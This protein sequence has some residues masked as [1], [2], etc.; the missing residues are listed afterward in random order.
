VLMLVSGFAIGQPLGGAERFGVG[1]ACHLDQEQFE[2]IVCGFW[3]RGVPAE[4]HWRSL[5]QASRIETFEA[6]DRSRGFTLARYA[7]A[8]RGIAGHL[9]G[10]P[11]D[12]IHSQFQLGS[13]T[14][15]LLRRKLGARALVRTAHNA[16][17]FEWGPTIEGALGRQI[18]TNWIFPLA[19]DAEVA[20][21]LDAAA[22]QDRRPGARLARKRTHL[23]HNGI[24]L[25]PSSRPEPGL[26][27]VLGLSATDTVIGSVGRFS[28]EK[29]YAYLVQAAPE[30]LA[31]RQ[32]VKFLLI[33]DG[34][35][36]DVLEQQV[37]GLGLTGSVIFAGARH[38]AASLYG[39]MDLFVLPSLYE[40]LPTAVLESMAA[41][42]PVVATATAGTRELV[43]D[44][45]TGWLCRSRD[46]A[47]LAEAILTAL[48]SPARRTLAAQAALNEVVPRYLLDRIADQYEELYR[49]LV[50]PRT[51][52]RRRP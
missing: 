39:V 17:P 2:P 13:V 22:S 44:G 21:S 36:R 24:N 11:V 28:S 5:L 15:L 46:P 48:G 50:T 32:D 10:R 52:F 45:H 25:P 8:L 30:V 14:A 18:F 40:G 31:Q 19:L 4:D 43:E 51:S 47:G 38:D 3:R 20:V 29:G 16:S 6:A 34:D 9:H 35:Q 26:R 41:G 33:G 42:V 7:S 49:S 27:A 23:I 1:L 37:A 12:V